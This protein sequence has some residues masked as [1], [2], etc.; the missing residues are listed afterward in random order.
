MKVVYIICIIAMILISGC[1]Q[2]VSQSTYTGSDKVDTV[3]DELCPMTDFGEGVLYFYCHGVKAPTYG[4]AFAKS[5]IK[6]K[7]EHP[8]M[9]ITAM[10]SEPSMGSYNGIYG[11]FVIVEEK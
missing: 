1:T 3:E 5:L 11:Y 7:K 4:P 2:P 8:N 10:D 6:Y 9:M